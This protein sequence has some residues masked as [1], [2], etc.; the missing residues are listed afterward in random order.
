MLGDRLKNFIAT[1]DGNR[2]LPGLRAGTP[3]AGYYEIDTAST[4]ADTWYRFFPSGSDAEKVTNNKKQINIGTLRSDMKHINGWHLKTLNT[5]HVNTYVINGYN[6]DI[7]DLSDDLKS[8]LP[9]TAIEYVLYPRNIQTLNLNYSEDSEENIEVGY[10]VDDVISPA[11][12]DITTIGFIA[13]GGAIII[14]ATAS[15]KV[16]YKFAI[17]D[18]AFI[19]W[20]EHL[21]I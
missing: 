1:D 14:P 8:E 7:A 18:D 3:V 16:F 10:V 13:P 20:G 6:N 9:N 21:I 19:S 12:S 4:T 5:E 17:V 11:D 15:D 2:L